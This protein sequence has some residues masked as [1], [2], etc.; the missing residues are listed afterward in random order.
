[1]ILRLTPDGSQRT[2]D[3]LLGR[4]AYVRRS[5]SQYSTIESTVFLVQEIGNVRTYTDI[6]DSDSGFNSG[7]DCKWAQIVYCMY[8]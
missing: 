6:R 4:S 7:S 2:V 5:P 1:M 8:M 3:S